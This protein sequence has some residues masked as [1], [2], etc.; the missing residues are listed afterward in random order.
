MSET[1]IKKTATVGHV[2]VYSPAGTASL[3]FERNRGKRT[4]RIKMLTTIEAM[5]AHRK[6]VRSDAAY[7]PVTKVSESVGISSGKP[8][9]LKHGAHLRVGSVVL[10]TGS[11]PLKI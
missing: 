1:S 3:T 9:S 8:R 7:A 10:T 4:G 5:R 11:T 2:T 6:V